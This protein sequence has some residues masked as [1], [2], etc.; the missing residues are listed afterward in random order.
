VG[1]RVGFPGAVGL[2]ATQGIFS[3]LKRDGGTDYVQTD[4]AVNPGNSG[5]PLVNGAGELVGIAVFKIRDAQGLNFAVAS[6]TARLFAEAG[7]SSNNYPAQDPVATAPGVVTTYY[8]FLQARQYYSAW[9][10]LSEDWRLGQPYSDYV[11]GFT[12]TISTRFQVASTRL[13]STTSATV[14]GNVVATENFP[15]NPPGFV[16]QSIY[17]GSYDVAFV[18]GRWVILVGTLELASR[19]FIRR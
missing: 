1:L 14:S 13:L 5:G 8:G 15:N 17:S 7:V 11:A 4:A 16:T 19:S 2:T 18:G 6:S 10:M 12:Q 9:S 3:G